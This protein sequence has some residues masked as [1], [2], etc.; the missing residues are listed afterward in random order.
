MSL[1]I[2]TS[3]NETRLVLGKRVRRSEEIV[4][5]TGHE[6]DDILQIMNVKSQTA[7]KS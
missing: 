1:C 4:G 2:F 5:W 6:P 3:A 7:L